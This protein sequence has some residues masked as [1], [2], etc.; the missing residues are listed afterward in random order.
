MRK[1]PLVSIYRQG[2]GEIWLVNH[3]QFMRNDILKK[4]ISNNKAMDW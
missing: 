3:P 1:K 2:Q 4:S